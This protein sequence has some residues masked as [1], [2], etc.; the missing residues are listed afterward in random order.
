MKHA[1]RRR[2]AALGLTVITVFAFAVPP[3]S[4]AAPTNDRLR[5]AIE[6]A[7]IP[8]TNTQSTLEAESDGPHFCSNNGSVFYSYTAAE[9][10]RLQAD[11]IGSD[12]DTVLGVFT[13]ELGDFSPIACNDDRFNLQSAVRFVAE[14][15]ETYHFM[16]GFCCGNGSDDTDRGGTLVFN[17]DRAR[18]GADLD[19]DFQVDPEAT[20]AADGSAVVSGTVDC[21]TDS[22][23]SISGT[24]RQLQGDDTVRGREFGSFG[25]DPSS[26]TQ[27]SLTIVARGDA[28]FLAGE[29]SFVYDLA[30]ESWDQ[31]LF[32]RN[33]HASVDL[34]SA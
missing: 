25:C 23:I 7:S 34:V 9:T 26:T 8:Y 28:S 15:G 20:V 18:K 22:L 16:I 29:A 21:T 19:V 2:L 11:T 1:H 14:A 24:L 32:V 6:I 33:R 12:Y 30:A 27:W 3:A 17:L 5:N 13:G 10:R 31:F 4:A